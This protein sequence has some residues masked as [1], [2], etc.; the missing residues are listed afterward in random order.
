MSEEQ[1]CA[2]GRDRE[3]ELRQL[4]A[5]L[6]REVFGREIL[7]EAWVD[8]WGDVC[9]ELV[10]SQQ[11]QE[12]RWRAWVYLEHCCCAERTWG[13]PDEVQVL[14]H[15]WQCLKPCARYASDPDDVNAAMRIVAELLPRCG[16]EFQQGAD[17]DASRWWASFGFPGAKHPYTVAEATT[18]QEAIARAALAFV[19]AEK[20]ASA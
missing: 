5:D 1:A 14:G 16:Y 8:T 9:G 19:R 7:G 3:Q 17:G 2:V 10:D 6:E 12:G 18:P 4:D 20:G 15:S 13:L 11:E